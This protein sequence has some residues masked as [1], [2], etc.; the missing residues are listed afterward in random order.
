MTELSIKGLHIEVEGEEI[1]KGVTLSVKSNEI[2]AIMG[3]NGSGKSTLVNTVMGHPK[4]KVT[5]GEILMDNKNMTD[6]SPDERAKAGL[7]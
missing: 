1:V 3:P 2:V 7:F 4:Y 6:A 5:N